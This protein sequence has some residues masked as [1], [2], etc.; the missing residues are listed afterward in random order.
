M[1]V[2]QDQTQDQTQDRIEALYYESDS[3]KYE[4]ERF[5]DECTPEMGWDCFDYWGATVYREYQKC[6]KGEDCPRLNE[7]WEM[8]KRL[9]S[10][11]K[12]IDDLEET[13]EEGVFV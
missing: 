2:T 12:L 13:C 10:V 3:L 9:E 6:E 5:C 8:E 11:L 4:M 1:S 7:Y